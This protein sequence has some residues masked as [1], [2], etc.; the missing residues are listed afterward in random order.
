MRDCF[1]DLTQTQVLSTAL[2]TIDVITT[3]MN[4][5]ATAVSMMGTTLIGH[6]WGAELPIIRL[7]GLHRGLV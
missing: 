4:G 6:A 1:P 7:S 2:K 5:L 3:A